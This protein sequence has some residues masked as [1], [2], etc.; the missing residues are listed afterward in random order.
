ME[1]KSI[2]NMRATHQSN[3]TSNQNRIEDIRR[4]A[5]ML[6]LDVERKEKMMRVKGSTVDDAS[7]INDMLIDA[8]EAKLAILSEI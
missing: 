1:S 7:E 3:L 6:E 8:I 5:K 4:K 2:D